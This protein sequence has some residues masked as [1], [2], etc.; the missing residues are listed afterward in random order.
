MS[1]DQKRITRREFLE[2]T[3]AGAAGA[4]ALGLGLPG[5]PSRQPPSAAGP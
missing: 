2:L 5:R 4:A 3:A 1:K